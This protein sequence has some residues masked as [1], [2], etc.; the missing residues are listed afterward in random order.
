M[1]NDLMIAVCGIPR[2][3]SLTE[4]GI[5]SKTTE[6]GIT[7]GFPTWRKT[8]RDTEIFNVNPGGRGD[9]I[10]RRARCA[11]FSSC[12]PGTTEYDSTPRCLDSVLVPKFVIGLLSEMFSTSNGAVAI[13]VTVDGALA[14]LSK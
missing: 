5:G 8:G 12:A 2:T 9:I 14:S 13:F 7:F 11:I 10:A 3:T 1:D 6:M 4:L